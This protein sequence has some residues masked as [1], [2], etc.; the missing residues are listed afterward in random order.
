MLFINLALTLGLLAIAVP[1]ILHLLNRR[2]AKR[3]DWGA[4]RFLIESVT[5]RRRRVQLEE[6]LLMVARCLLFALLALALARPFVPPGAGAPWVVV[7]PLGL[8]A[9][10]AL[11]VAVAMWAEPKPRLLLLATSLILF[12]LCAAAVIFERKLNLKRFGGG[13]R[14]DIAL[15]IDGSSSMTL[16]AGGGTETNFAKAVAE[17]REIIEKASGGDAI[18][19]VLGGPVPVGKLPTPISDRALLFESL[20]ALQPVNGS[21]AGREA[22]AYAAAGLSQGYNPKKRIIVIT[23][24]QSLG[25]DADTPGKWRALQEG[26][27]GLPTAPEVIVRQLAVPA[28]VRNAAVVDVALSRTVVGTDRPVTI[29]VTVENTGTEAVTPAG[30]E[31]DLG[32]GTVLTGTPPGQMAPGAK[33]VVTFQ[34]QFEKPGSVLAEARVV[35]EDDIVLDDTMPRAI[36]V[37]GEVRVLLVDGSASSAFFERASA[38]ASLA[39]AP[40]FVESSAAAAGAEAEGGDGQPA[41]FL[42]DPEVVA[43]SQITT[44]K[45]FASYGVIVLADVPRLPEGV[46]RQIARFVEAGGG[47]MVAAGPQVEPAFYNRWTATEGQPVLPLALGEAVSL[48]GAD[49]LVAPALSTFSHPALQLL[50][51]ASASDLG[52]AGIARYWQLEPDT[53]DDPGGRVGARFANGDAFLAEGRL[54]AGSV[55]LVPFALDTKAGNFATRQAFVPF[56]HELIYHLTNPGGAGLNL[57]PTWALT[58]D[59]SAGAGGGRPGAQGLFAQYFSDQSFTRRVVSRVDPNVE[60]DW[61]DGSP[62]EG[63]PNDRFA[64]RWTGSITPRYSERY[65]FGVDADDELR[66]WIDGD[67]IID[68]WGSAHVDM[69]AGR[70]YAIRLDFIEGEGNAKARL[71]WKSES[72]SWKAVPG[73]ALSPVSPGTGSGGEDL[74][75]TFAALAPDGTTRQAGVYLTPGGLVSRIGGDVIPGVYRIAVPED[76]R[77]DYAALLESGKGDT[78]ASEIPF[79]VARDPQESRLEALTDE[80]FAALGSYVNLLRPADVAGVLDILEGREYGKELWRF[81]AAAGLVLLVVE[82]VLSRWISK[83]RAAGVS[84]PVAFE[85]SNQPGQAFRDQLGRMREAGGGT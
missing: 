33:E 83:N 41:R 35:V 29:D 66:V 52:T 4:M 57:Q 39:L 25:W 72:E 63:V 58:I 51:D 17:A 8:L 77:A 15:V 22:V 18:S 37:S 6:A 65:E 27:A 36:N 40:G 80:D 38:F 2:T 78:P 7:L 10:A 61:G 54:G 42:V 56:I 70:P 44:I 68:R 75:D 67:P 43:A 64:V 76:R 16:A 20:D 74:I 50:A 69:E 5:S 79:T 73:S 31:L 19:L 84:Q 71:N 60:F 48:K 23:D 21:M 81:L 49:E 13:E 26:F 45:S 1:V 14:Q 82:V 28:R 46:A 47:L 55:I 53:G 34:H 24:G 32:G 59:L 12:A 3:I 30:V 85:S 11:G 9:V 62:A